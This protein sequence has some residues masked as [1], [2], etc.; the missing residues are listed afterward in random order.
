[1]AWRRAVDDAQA[2]FQRA[3]AE[4]VEEYDREAAAEPRG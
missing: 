1:M 4:K 2:M 3:W